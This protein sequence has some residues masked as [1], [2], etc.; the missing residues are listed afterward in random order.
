MKVLHLG[1]EHNF[2]SDSKKRFEEFYPGQNIFVA[3]NP[4]GE[5]KMLKDT[6][7][8]LIHDL[9]KNEQQDQLIELCRL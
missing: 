3:H 7:G 4:L 9:S 8:F 1:R 6:T 5:F 2:I